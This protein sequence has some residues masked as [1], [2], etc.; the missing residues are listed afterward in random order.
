MH[1]ASAV[2]G[3]RIPKWHLLSIRRSSAAIYG[4]IW[5]S[6]GL[7][8]CRFGSERALAF[9]HFDSAVVQPASIGRRRW[10]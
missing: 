5:M 10:A 8:S 6:N 3:R 2:K 7:Y 9:C 4:N 1:A